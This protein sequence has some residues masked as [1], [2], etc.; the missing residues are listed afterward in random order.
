MTNKSQVERV[1]GQLLKVGY[2][3]RNQA[4][5][6]RITRLSAIIWTLEHKFGMKFKT[7]EGNDGDYKYIKLN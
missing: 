4:L 2:V 7:E 5:D 6:C 1:R 3:T